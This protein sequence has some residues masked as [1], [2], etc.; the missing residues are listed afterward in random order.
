ML[1]ELAYVTNKEDAR[2]LNSEAWRQKVADSIVTAVEN[3][4][5]YQVARLPM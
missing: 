2:N 5:S 4:F 3:Y 1:I